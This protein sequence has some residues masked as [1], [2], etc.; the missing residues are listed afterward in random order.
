MNDLTGQTGT[1]GI[2]RLQRNDHVFTNEMSRLSRFPY[3]AS[4]SSHGVHVSSKLWHLR[5]RTRSKPERTNQGTIMEF[6]GGI[7]LAVVLAAS[8][9]SSETPSKVVDTNV[10]EARQIVI[11]ADKVAP[12]GDHRVSVDQKVS[13]PC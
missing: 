7:A 1:R 13:E 12:S 2:R 10:E 9:F 4:A 6:K 5:S 8:L 11:A 3:P